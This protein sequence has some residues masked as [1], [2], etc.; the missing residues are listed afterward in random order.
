MTVILNS[1]GPAIPLINLTTAETKTRYLAVIHVY[2]CHTTNI[3]YIVQL[4]IAFT[5]NSVNFEILE[6]HRLLLGLCL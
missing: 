3:T 2:Y 5:M 4:F 6:F 1:L